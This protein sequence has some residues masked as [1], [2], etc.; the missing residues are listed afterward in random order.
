MVSTSSSAEHVAAANQILTT[1]RLLRE[2]VAA[3][4][5]E[6]NKKLSEAL[7]EVMLYSE[8][9]DS[10]SR[11]LA[12]ADS[13]IGQI[14]S[15]MRAHGIS[16]HLPPMLPDAATLSDSANI[17]VTLGKFVPPKCPHELVLTR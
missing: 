9:V 12:L 2:T 17:S 1:A 15:R 11:L 8:K 13:C 3:E 7:L 4:S 10:T 14:R 6:A 16:I 5:T